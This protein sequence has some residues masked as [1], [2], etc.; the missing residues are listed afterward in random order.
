MGGYDNLDKFNLACHGDRWERELSSVGLEYFPAYEIFWRR[1]VVPLTNRI[2]PGISFSL[3]G[4]RWIRLR[5]DVEKRPEQMAMH[6]YSVF[7]YLAR[8][9]SRIHSDKRECP[10]DIF[11]LLDACGDNALDFCIVMRTILKDFGAKVKVDFLPQQDDELCCARKRSKGDKSR[12]GLVEVQEYRDAIL[13]NPVLGRGI[14]APRELLPK[15]E[16]LAKGK[17]TWREAAC[18]KPEQLIDSGQL[19]SRLLGEIASFLQETWGA[20]IRELDVLRDTDK[21]KKQ[22]RIHER[23]LPIA[24][25]PVIASTN[26]SLAASGWSAAPCS[27]SA[28]MPVKTIPLT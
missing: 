17:L 1:Y 23:F 27:A 7:Y 15:R 2:D 26:Q 28:V 9:A 13:H 4:D 11:S 21:L 12:G 24:S 25:P 20:L 14:G 18:L 3:D 5:D 16:F 8:A 22:W 6:H 19:Y 10:E